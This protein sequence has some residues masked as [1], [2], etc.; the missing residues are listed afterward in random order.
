MLLQGD[1]P[2]DI[3]VEKEIQTLVSSGLYQ[4]TVLCGN[5]KAK[6]K[7]EKKRDV[8]V[9]RLAF[10]P[11][12]GTKLNWIKNYPLWFNLTWMLKGIQVLSQVKP[13]IIHVHDLPLVFL[14]LILA[15]LSKA[16]LIYDL[17]E[18][19]PATFDIW[20]KGGILSPIVRNKR[21]AVWYDR[22]AI[23]KANGVI[24]IEPE[25]EAWIRKT[26]S[27]NREVSIVPNTVDLEYYEST[28]NHARVSSEF[29]NRFV[30]TYV[31]MIS[32]ERD[33]DIAVK[34]VANLRKKIPNILLVIV[35]EGPEISQLKRLA[36]Q[37]KLTNEV[38]FTGWVPFD[39]TK[40]YIQMSQ[41]CLITRRSNDWSDLGTPHKLYQYMILGKP[42]VT[43]D[44]KAIKRVVEETK[45][46]EVFES[47]NEKSMAK[48]I[49]KINRNSISYGRNGHKAVREKY[50]WQNTSKSLIQL[51]AGLT[52]FN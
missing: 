2:P 11:H 38:V 16:K 18:N 5:R 50:N 6:E 22:F 40:T 4:V 7:L 41:I 33:L 36:N 9:I 31:G 52:P 28:Q 14:G 29:E 23:R 13:E 35:G 10:W 17:H 1:F 3:R 48:A 20:E 27:L 12:L 46:G 44:A 8:L 49:M 39:E 51:Y 32:E 30:I 43:S 25:H 26:Y 47:R 34:G 45:C 37:L 15:R 42:I 21:L 19:Y 24:V